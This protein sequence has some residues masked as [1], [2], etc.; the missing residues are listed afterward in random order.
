MNEVLFILDEIKYVGVGAGEFGPG[1]LP[2]GVIPYDPVAHGQIEFTGN[3]AYLRGVVVT[4]GDPERAVVSQ[5]FATGPHPLFAPL[6]IMLV[7]EFVLVLV[8]LVADI[9]RRISE[10]QIDKG[11]ALAL[12]QLGPQNF[13]AVALSNGIIEHEGHCRVARSGEQRQILIP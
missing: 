11:L 4:A 3:N 7:L 9:E 10:N 5:N 8:I 13:D 12:I 6:D 1:V 2:E